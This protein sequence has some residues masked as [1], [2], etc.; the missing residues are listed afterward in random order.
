MGQKIEYSVIF[1]RTF[2][3]IRRGIGA[4]ERERFFFCSKNFRKVE[5]VYKVLYASKILSQS[6]N[7]HRSSRRLHGTLK[8]EEGPAAHQSSPH[9]ALMIP[10]IDRL[11]QAHQHPPAFPIHVLGPTSIPQIRIQ[12]PLIHP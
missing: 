8:A 9:A 12:H 1:F 6:Q 11:S 4:Y 3:S 5:W 10:H 2:A 7:A